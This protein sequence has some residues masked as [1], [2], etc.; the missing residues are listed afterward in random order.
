MTRRRLL[1][2]VV[3]VVAVL[4][5]LVLA[6]VI[7]RRGERPTFITGEVQRGD[8]E[9]MVSTTGTL[10]AVG[11]VEVG[12]QVSGTIEQVMV[13]YNDRVERAQVL[14]VL[15]TDLFE[16]SVRDAEAGLSKARAQLRQARADYERSIDLY[17]KGYLSD[18]EFLGVETSVE[19]AGAAVTSAEAS[20]ERAETNLNYAGIRSPIDGTVIERAIEPGQTI[21]ASLQSPRLFLIAEDLTRMEIEADV[22]ETDIGRIQVGQEVRFTVE[23]YPDRVFEGTAR[24]VQLNPQTIQNVVHYNVV[25][26]APNEDYL[27]LPGMTATVDFIIYRSEDALLVP[28]SALDL[29]PEEFS[30]RA[31]EDNVVSPL[32]QDAVLVLCMNEEGRP[33]PV[34]IRTG[35]TDGI[36]T[37]VVEGR[38]LTQGSRVVTGISGGDGE[39]RERAGKFPFSPPAGG[40]GGRVMRGPGM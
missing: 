27:L 32:P 39:G 24:Q 6:R 7:S 18:A 13:D 29:G 40:R 10:S 5:T 11:T 35:E 23:A 1:I 14:A 22:D 3:L 19:S 31:V 38:G 30:G 8:L 15:D 9:Q 12:S 20:L 17:E 26:D 4:A 2:I 21:A 34:M 36:V 37:E 25:V 33:E 16:A 28:N